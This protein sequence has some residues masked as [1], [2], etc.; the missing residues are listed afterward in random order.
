MDGNLFIL[1]RSDVPLPSPSPS[2]APRR[3]LISG[4]LLKIYWLAGLGSF[5]YDMYWL[6]S[7][8]YSEDFG[9]EVFIIRVTFSKRMKGLVGVGGYWEARK[10]E[11][12]CPLIQRKKDNH[13]KSLCIHVHFLESTAAPNAREG[14]C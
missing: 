13:P 11:C 6:L 8:M 7:N 4:S 5:H 9:L 3:V 14:A 2:D 10:L 1:I 12:S